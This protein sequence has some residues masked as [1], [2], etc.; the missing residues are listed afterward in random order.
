MV[1][2]PEFCIQ[3]TDCNINAASIIYWYWTVKL[4]HTV[5]R[6]LFLVYINNITSAE[7]ARRYGGCGMYIR[8]P[9][10]PPITIARP[11]EICTQPVKQNTITPYCNKGCH[12]GVD[13]TDEG[14]AHHKLP[15][16]T[17]ITDIRKPR[18]EHLTTIK[19]KE[20]SKKQQ[21]KIKT[22]L[23]WSKSA[24][25]K[26]EASWLQAQKGRL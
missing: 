24:H 8:Q 9:N 10:M 13:K 12:P 18:R 17:A 25:Q 4:E 15:I 19:T 22:K 23:P 20:G 26:Q 6:F 5:W 1:D 11:V 7:N 16:S 2:I 21:P 3:D 14:C